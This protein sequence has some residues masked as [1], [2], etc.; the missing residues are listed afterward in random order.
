MKGS[1]LYIS[2]MEI[3]IP[4]AQ[5][6]IMYFLQGVLG[7]ILFYFYFYFL[8]FLFIC[9][10][11]VWVISPPF[12]HPSLTPHPFPSLSPHPLDTRQNRKNSCNHIPISV[13]ETLH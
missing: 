12:P 2:L 5:E 10:Y 7:K 3:K 11:N 1:I 8:F 6:Y 4:N 13:I 9:A